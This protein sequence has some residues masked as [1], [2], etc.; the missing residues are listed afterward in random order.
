[1]DS[2]IGEKNVIHFLPKAPEMSR[3]E[4]VDIHASQIS[5]K[6]PIQQAPDFAYAC[7]ESPI[8]NHY[9]SES[10]LLRRFDQLSRT[11]EV[12][13]ER[14]FLQ[15]MQSVGKAFHIHVYVCRWNCAVE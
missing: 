13:S 9:V 15:D 7:V 10:L 12:R 5:N 6:P 11:G 14:L 1:M 4:K 2:H 8:L 3:H